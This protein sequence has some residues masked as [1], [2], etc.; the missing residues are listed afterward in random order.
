MRRATILLAGLAAMLLPGMAAADQL[1][2][3]KTASVVSDPVNT[4]APK[5]IPGAIVDYRVLFTNPAT[6]AL[7]PVRNIT[8]DDVLP[9]R[10]IL[11]VAD[12][13]G[14]GKGPVEF[15]DGSLLGL[16]LGSSNLSCT[17][18]SL[19]S[20]TDCV[21]FFDGTSWGYVPTPDADGFD[22]RVSAIRLKPTTTFATSGSFQ[23]RYR[24]KIR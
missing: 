14:T 22:S 13:A 10:V 20:A 7:L 23:I 16:G 2:V 8:V 4:I 19:A 24:V 21:D 15:L 18:T 6:N 12:L 17:F 5:A 11:R 1:S 9:A 3:T